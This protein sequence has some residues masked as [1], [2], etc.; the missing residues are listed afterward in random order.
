VEFV[1]T[2]DRA[3]LERYLRRDT[4]AQLYAL[5]DLDDFFFGDTTWFALLENDRLVAAAL[6][7]GKLSL[8]VLYAVCPPDHEP[9]YL[10]L[11]QLRPALPDHFFVN[12]GVGFETVYTEDHD[13]EPE[14]V[15]LKYAL[16]DPDALR[17]IDTG[18]V[19]LVGREARSELEAFYADG[20]YLTEERESRFLTD[21]MLE[22]WPFAVIREAGRI[23]SC[24]GVHV[25]S[26]RYQV[27]ALG[28]IA[29]RPD[30]RGRGLAA[31]TTASLTRWLLERT[32]D[33]G[34][35]VHSENAAAIRCYE[36]LGFRSVCSYIE[37]RFTRL[38]GR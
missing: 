29:T 26:E 21:Y 4:G 2:G 23:V 25:L 36:R 32:D 35:N 27:A 8:P 7:L 33:V 6:L 20:A 11:E 19:E 34:L 31:A 13:Y 30:A 22:R 5:A 9:T 12:L 14:G 3:A 15:H 28:N 38:G 16:A 18:A 1:Q 24:A 10:L 17:A 37:G